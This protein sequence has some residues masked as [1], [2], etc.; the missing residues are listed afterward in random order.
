MDEKLNELFANESEQKKTAQGGLAGTAQ[1]TAQAAIITNDIMR[2]LHSDDSKKASV[3]A[4]K[5]DNDEM[6]AL[7][8]SCYDLKTVNVDYLKDI[9]PK[10]LNSMIKSQQSKRSR[11][12]TKVMTIVNY[13]SMMTAAVAENLLRIVTNQPKSSMGSLSR[14]LVEFSEEALQKLAADQ[15]KLGKEIR[16]V[17]SKKSIDKLKADHSITSPKWLALLKAE[18]QLK[19]IRTTGDRTVV[20]SKMS[21][22]IDKIITSNGDPAAA[23]EAIKAMLLKTTVAPLKTKE[24][25]AEVATP[26][27]VVT[28]VE[29]VAEVKPAETK[30]VAKPNF[31]SSKN[32]AKRR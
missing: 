4:S 5:K 15:D 25:P 31:N 12:K 21:A 16:N 10:E 13:K 7:I 9:S 22:E 3:I 17:Q 18:E 27:E 19:A 14:G 11:S 32:N 26:V 2:A 1:L 6:D 29:P 24:V 23:L 20:T 8:E 30:P 28:V